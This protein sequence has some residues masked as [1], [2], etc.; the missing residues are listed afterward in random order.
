MYQNLTRTLVLGTLLT[1]SLVACQDAKLDD[2]RPAADAPTVVEGRLKFS[3]LQSFQAYLTANQTKTV[4]QLIEGNKA[5][6]FVSHLRL[7]TEPG[8][9]PPKPVYPS[10]LHCLRDRAHPAPAAPAS[11]ALARSAA[12]SAT[13]ATAEDGEGEQFAAVDL[14][15]ISP[16]MV[17]PLFDSV[18]DE[19]REAIIGE[20]IYRAGNDYCFYYPA[21]QEAL[22]DD[23]YQRVDAGE[24]NILDTEMHAYGNLI[25]QRVC[26][27]THPT[28]KGD[29]ISLSD[30][31]VTN[32]LFPIPFFGNRSVEGNESWDGN[33]RIECQIWQGNWGV[34]ASSGIKTHATQYA[35]KWLFFWGW[36]DQKVSRVGTFAT[37][38][39]TVPT[40]IPVSGGSVPVSSPQMVKAFDVSETNAAVAVRRF[41]WGTAQFGYSPG[42]GQVLQFLLSQMSVNI[43]NPNTGPS[44]PATL[45]VRISSLTSTHTGLW[46][47]RAIQRTLLW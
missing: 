22:I 42:G 5:L 15:Y 46:N 27:V 7:D 20:I 3:S 13:S 26:L 24:I 33:H 8:L 39:Y 44:A 2:I 30:E 6:G 18:L 31:P 21:G 32:S 1:T 11:P 14:E 41:D 36:V 25:A 9:A 10:T 17:D 45:N 19:N 38:T 43:T 12:A 23:F 35:R 28:R 34:Y 16:V 4:E 29:V 37:L 47:G 40:V